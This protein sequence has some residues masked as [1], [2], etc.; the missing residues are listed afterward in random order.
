VIDIDAQRFAAS[1]DRTPLRVAHDL[2]DEQLLDVQALVELAERHPEE[3]V[4]HNLGAVPVTAPGGEVPRLGRTGA[5]VLAEI[6][7][8]GS[9][10][11][12]KNVERDPRYRALLDRLLDEVDPLVPGGEDTRLLRE[13][14]VFVSAPGSV[15]PAHV[16]PEHNFL[17]QVRGGKIM[18]VGAFGDDEVRARELERF[19][20]GS[21]RNIEQVPA[22]LEAVGLQPGQGIYVPPDAPHWVQ[23]GDEVSI[24]LSITWRTP[25]TSRR[26]RLWAANHRMRQR[27][28]S[29]QLPGASRLEDA[30]KLA[31]ARAVQVRERVLAGRS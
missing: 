14:F 21:H 2:Q 15:T 23:N 24:S 5:Q 11:V 13:A 25:T 9:W 7:E 12:L 29:P 20:S 18:H 3:L 4:E 10:L 28:R 26:G 16:D 22:D 30:R 19:H 31:G 8:N 6:A 17:L 1:Y 27:G